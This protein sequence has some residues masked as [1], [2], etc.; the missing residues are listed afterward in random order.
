MFQFSKK[1]FYFIFILIGSF[2]F[3][4]DMLEHNIPSVFN[5]NRKPGD[6]FGEI[7]AIIFWFIF[8]TTFIINYNKL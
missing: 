2:F 7:L 8:T 1:N 5:P 6:S 4:I 3:I